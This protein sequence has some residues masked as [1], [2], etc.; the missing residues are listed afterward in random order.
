M[1]FEFKAS[2]LVY[3][4]I[5]AIAL[6]FSCIVWT[7]RPNRGAAPFSLFILATTAWMF[8]RMLESASGQWETKV[9][10]AQMMYVLLVGAMLCWLI[11]ASDYSGLKY[12]KRPR[13]LLLLCA[14]PLISIVL[15]LTHSWHGLDWLNI[16]PS[17]DSSGILVVWQRDAFYW[18]Q[19]GYMWMLVLAGYYLLWKF[20]LKRRGVYRN[21]IIVLLA[22]T[23]IPGLGIVIFS[24][25]FGYYRG[26]DIIPTVLIFGIVVYAVAIFRFRFLNVVPVA[27]GALFEKMPDGIL[28]LDNESAIMDVNPAAEGLFGQKKGNVTGQML[29]RVW[30]QIDSAYNQLR[31]GKHVEITIG[32]QQYLDMTVTELF[33]TDRHSVG[34]MVVLRDITERR[35]MEETLRESESRYAT[36]VEQSNEAVVIVQ[37]DM[38]KFVNHTFSEISG[39]TKEEVIGRPFRT[40]ISEGDRAMVEERHSRRVTGETTPVIYEVKLAGKDGTMRDAE[41]SIGEI[42]YARKSAHIITARDITE[43]KMTQRKLEVLYKEEKQLRASLQVEMDKRNRYTRALVHELNTPLTSILVS[44]EMLE[45]EVVDTTLSALVKN[46]RRASNNLKQRIDELIELARGEIGILKINAMPVDIVK[47]LREI[48]SEMIPLASGKGLNMKVEIIGELP[49]AMGDRGRLRQVLY[50]LIGNAL[51]FTQAGQICVKGEKAGEYVEVSVRDTGRGISQAEMEHLFDPYLRKVNEGQ[52]LGGLG[53]GLTLSKMFVELHGGKIEVESEV[54]KGSTFHFT[55][56]V[57]QQAN[58]IKKFSES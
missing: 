24:L 58:L 51:K 16:H 5:I 33:D 29:T 46:I 31:P 23:L 7:R 52:E 50:N 17:Y 54:G 35:K 28:V 9:I 19:A 48:E 47:L 11:F 4:F 57:Y 18:V 43:R 41:I 39:Y 45:A 12:W 1:I 21:Q 22:G 2:S 26:L 53:I 15:V 44:G 49:L 56:P 42:I 27:R 37:D 36:L 3:L 10:L 6:Y 32:G 40:L 34:R 30:P 14:V 55:V 25:G 20:I 13:N 8:L 38:V